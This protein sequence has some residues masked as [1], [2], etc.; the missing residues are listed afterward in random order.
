MTAC[1]PQTVDN[2]SR[3]GGRIGWPALQ[4]CRVVIT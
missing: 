1:R 4:E 2:R 3:P